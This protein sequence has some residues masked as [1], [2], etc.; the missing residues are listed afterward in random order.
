MERKKGEIFVFVDPIDSAHHPFVVMDR[1]DENHYDCCMLTTSGKYSDNIEMEPDHFKD[2]DENGNQYG[3]RYG[4]VVDGTFKKS[5]FIKVGLIKEVDMVY[6]KKD[7]EL[8]STGIEC[9]E[10]YKT[11]EP[12]I[13]WSA[14]LKRS[15]ADRKKRREQGIA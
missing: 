1:I 3:T 12:A 8:T 15:R 13:T 9:I 6:T 2:L 10:G 5:H 7:G 14:Y 4:K 11:K